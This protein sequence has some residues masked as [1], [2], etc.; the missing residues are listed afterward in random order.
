MKHAL[1]L[2][3]I[4][5]CT[6]A[7]STAQTLHL[8]PG[9]VAIG[10]FRFSFVSHKD[11]NQSSKCWVGDPFPVNKY[12]RKWAPIECPY[13]I[14]QCYD[15]SGSVPCRCY[16]LI[17]RAIEPPTLPVVPKMVSHPKKYNGA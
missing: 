15:G 2:L 17:S 6:L 13:F 12:F 5:A 10:S 16:M 9:Q 4:A 7:K 14:E 11:F 3:F 8:E 1:T